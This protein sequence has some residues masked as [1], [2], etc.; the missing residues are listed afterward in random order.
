MAR[1]GI[2]RDQQG[3]EGRYRPADQVLTVQQSHGGALHH[4][5]E[6]EGKEG[7][8]GG[9]GLACWKGSKKGR[10]L[11]TW[12]PGPALWGRFGSSGRHFWK[13]RFYKFYRRFSIKKVYFNVAEKT[14][15]L[16]KNSIWTFRVWRAAVRIWMETYFS[17]PMN[18]SIFPWI[19]L[20]NTALPP[21]SPP[22][23]AITPPPPPQ[24]TTL[25]PFLLLLLLL[26]LTFLTCGRS[27]HSLLL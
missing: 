10:K 5:Q 15:L 17:A 26:L 4:L 3:R 19:L 12:L 1:A 27:R 14:D 7:G 11:C 9:G 2:W 24:T 20:V 16:T 22:A 13:Q 25:V 8:E 18:L 23:P 21:D 6:G